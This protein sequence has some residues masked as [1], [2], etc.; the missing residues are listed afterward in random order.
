MAAQITLPSGRAI[1]QTGRLVVHRQPIS[2]ALSPTL[3]LAFK[4][5]LIVIAA[6]LLIT[7]GKAYYD[8]REFAGFIDQQIAAGF[9]RSHAGFYAAPRII[10]RGA[11]INQ[12]QLITALQ[13]AGY[14]RETSSNIWNGSFQTNDNSILIFPRKG[15]DAHD[16]IKVNFGQERVVSL[17]ANDQSNL[18]SYALEPEL[19]T[20]DTANKLGERKTL[21]FE[22]IPQVM[23]QA[24]LAIEDRRFFQHSGL[25]FRGIGR[26]AIDH[27]KSGSGR[28]RQGGSTITQQL[29]KN[30]YL[31]S[32]KT[33]RRK[34][35]EA[36]IALALEN[37]L[38]KQDIFSLYCN[39]VY[40]G[41][42]AG[43]GVRGV[44][45]AAKVYF[46]KD[47][48]DVSLAEAATISGMI[49]SPGRYS[50]DRN[51][52]ATRARRDTVIAAMRREG[53]IAEDVERFASAQAINLAP[54]EGSKNELA[55]YYVD[56]VDRA[57]DTARTSLDDDAEQSMRVQ[58]TIDPD[59][60]TA[61]E[62]ALRH[63]LELVAKNAKRGTPQG[64]I[65][66]I[67]PHTGNVLAMVGG[68]SYA[69]SQLNRATDA[70]RQPG[71]VFKP[72]VYAAALEG[73]LS[74]LR[75][76]LD[77]PQTFQNGYKATYAPANYGNSYS[78]HEVLMRE[79]LV[80][81]LN[82][83][84]VELAISTGLSRVANFAADFGLPKPAPYPAL[85]LG[86]TEVTPLQI[87]AAYAAF[88][89]G[90]KA[91]VPT[92][93][94]RVSDT[95][96]G[97]IIVDERPQSK[98][99]IRESTAYMITDMLSDVIKRGTARRAQI[100][101][102]N[103]AVAGKTGTSRDG[104]FVGYTPN[105]VCAVWIGFDDN[106]QLGLTGAE[107]ALP[108]WTDFIREAV[109][110]R[111]SLGGTSFPK[112]ADIITVRIDP[113]S[114]ALAGPSCPS[115]IVVSVAQ[116]FAPAVECW[117]HAPLYYETGVSEDYE[118]NS[119]IEEEVD[120]DRLQEQF[121]SVP[122]ARDSRIKPGDPDVKS[123]TDGNQTPGIGM[124]YSTN[125]RDANRR[126]QAGTQERNGQ[127]RE[128]R[129]TQ[130]ELNRVGRP[131]LVTSP[132]PP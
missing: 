85:A 40:L 75:T 12:Q 58:T 14:G 25:D 36:L 68:R 2:L 60:Q 35:N 107:A 118:T 84:T 70:K 59:L 19:L 79:G 122:D 73:G 127:T 104:W 80:R 86:T 64:A 37:R 98:R 128:I 126:Q 100:S 23:I 91:I 101:F 117:K 120:A 29:V 39:E 51:P 41:Q 95:N 5:G 57:M 30:T 45:Q 109:A 8:Y 99:V 102:K 96:T 130:S 121:R 6:A 65:V 87:A 38:S 26:A 82:V 106:K 20:E 1:S 21:T 4:I 46:G 10:E 33:L 92:V 62:N 53:M 88:A 83:V 113:E 7:F 72:F 119:N 47:L 63:Q 77:A 105:L 54:F 16:W 22:E 34:Y 67:D 11:K 125:D 28:Y 32:E 131:T 124:D 103:V 78:M 50:P 49:Q 123:S 44:A 52:D 132:R 27:F 9:L 43:V 42:R 89:N 48:K 31:S 112:P 15:S 81:S 24:I 94:R 55:P 74:P 17:T 61:A 69:E 90:G 56:S 108:A 18:A 110:I 116:K 3:R 129:R 114:G 115:S 13:Q 111:P 93:V 76:F 66:A 97:E 71:S